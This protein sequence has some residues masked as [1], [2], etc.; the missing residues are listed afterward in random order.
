MKTIIQIL[1]FTVLL[2]AV[3]CTAQQSDHD[4]GL[5]KLTGEPLNRA[6]SNF[7]SGNVESTNNVAQKEM[8]PEEARQKLKEMGHDWFYGQGVG[9]TAL[10]IGTVVVFPPYGLYLLSNAVLGLAGQQ[11]LYITDILP[12]KPKEVWQGAYD[13]VT[14]VPGRVSAG[15]TGEQFVE[16]KNK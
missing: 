8:T 14:S 12:E 2:F 11:P 3:G 4:A 1:A 6:S 9:K 7:L 13:E 16:P 15:L 5:Q 10:N